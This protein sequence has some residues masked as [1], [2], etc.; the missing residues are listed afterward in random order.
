MFAI[1]MN[2]QQQNSL[3]NNIFHTLTL[4]IMKETLLNVTRQGL[5]NNTKNFLQLFTG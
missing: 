3:K 2:F 1:I 5:S 4:K